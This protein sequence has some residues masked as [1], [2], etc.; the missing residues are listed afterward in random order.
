MMATNG[1]APDFSIPSLR[2]M[3]TAE[4]QVP[5]NADEIQVLGS[6]PESP[7]LEWWNETILRPALKPEG[8]TSPRVVRIRALMR[9]LAPRR[10][11]PPRNYATLVDW[12]MAYALAYEELDKKSDP[13]SDMLVQIQAAIMLAG[14]LAV[15]R[16]PTWYVGRDL[17]EKILISDPPADSVVGDLPWPMP[18]M[19]YMLP[20]E[21]FEFATPEGARQRVIAVAGSREVTTRDGS[22][23]VLISM[24]LQRDNGVLWP[25]T[26]LLMLNGRLSDCMASI[27]R[28]PDKT[29][30]VYGIGVNI[31][32]RVWLLLLARPGVATQEKIVRSESRDRRGRL[33]KEALWSPNILGA[34]EIVSVPIGGTHASP[35]MHWRRGH[36]RRQRIGSLEKR[37]YKIVWIE[38]V[39]VGENEP[40]L[41]TEQDQ[42]SS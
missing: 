20:R 27:D 35:R 41:P 29:K 14:R 6:F 10:Y 5:L 2:R 12:A 28:H 33:T 42:S 36:Y 26:Q 32:L 31:F 11:Q 19:V 4:L 13:E 34:V 22:P 23:Y 15:A 1:S 40:T 24:L 8:D 21:R 16:V 37:E 17:L 18:A 9:C 30:D 25:Y 7:T 3:V 38:P 39:L